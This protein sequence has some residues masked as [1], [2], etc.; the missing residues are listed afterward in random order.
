VTSAF[1][2][3]MLAVGGAIYPGAR[4]VNPASA[5]PAQ[6]TSAP[7]ARTSVFATPTQAAAEPTGEMPGMQRALSLADS[8]RFEAAAEVAR[9]TRE[10][11]RLAVLSSVYSRWAGERPEEAAS[12]ALAL[13]DNAQRNLA[14][15]TVATRWAETDPAALAVHAW[16]L[17]EESARGPALDAALPRWMQ[18]DETAAL[19][20]VG[21]LPSSRASDSAVAVIAGHPSLLEHDPELAVCWAET[22]HDPDLRSRT[23]AAVARAWLLVAPEAAAGYARRSPDILPAHREDILVGERFT[24]HP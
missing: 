22:I 3:L 24:A 10:E 16:S 20:W 8:G 12:A 17:P 14:W 23:L 21:S 5:L 2:L 7:A 11:L 1:A 18:L 4:A 9:T 13:A 15:H 19:D 6:Q